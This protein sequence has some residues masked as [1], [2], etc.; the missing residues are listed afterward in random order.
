MTLQ[1]N[2]KSGFAGKRIVVIGD[3][4]ADQFLEGTI[5]RV[6]R[7][8]PVFILRHDETTTFPGGAANAAANVAA[9][10]AEAILIGY[11]GTDANGQAL[12][13]SLQ[14]RN[15]DTSGLVSVPEMPTI[16]KIRVLAGHSHAN[17]QQVIRIDYDDHST[18]APEY[19]AALVVKLLEAAKTA[20]AIII[21]DYGYDV[22]SAS[23]FA[24]AKAIAKDRHIPIVI[25]SRHRLTEFTGAT[26]AT[27]N[28]EEVE[29]ILGADFTA[30]DCSRLREQLGLEALLVTNGNK[31]MALFQI[32]ADPVTIPVVGSAQPVDGTGAG[33]TVIAAYTLALAAGMSFQEAAEVANHA[34]GIVVMKKGTATVTAAELLESLGNIETATASPAYTK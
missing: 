10:G 32:D 26:T 7:E 21:S 14:K 33:D 11:I 17:R 4:L 27:P 24:A 12:S 18:I 20:D 23:L 9:L 5:S 2:V 8:A 19:L 25:D 31:G 1:Q 6:S 29:Q 15:V 13:T 3:A 30:E 22:V 16:T 28:R 34:G